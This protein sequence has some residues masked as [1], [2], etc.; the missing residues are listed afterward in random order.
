MHDHVRAAVLAAFAADALSL[1]VHWIYNTRV[2][3]RKYGR[4]ET[5]LKPELA[6]FHA[7][8]EKGDLT[9][10]GDQMLLL[11]ETVVAAGGF[12]PQAFAARWQAFAANYGG[13]MDKASKETLENFS[14]GKR[15]P[16][17]GSASTD[18]AGAARI[19]PLLIHYHQRPEELVAAARDQTAV[20]HNHPEVIACAELY[21]RAVFRVLAG[22]R[23]VAAL[24]DA[25]EETA[26]ADR[27]RDFIAAGLDSQGLDTRAAILDLGQACEVAQALP[28]TIHLIASYEDDLKTALVENIMAGGDSAARGMLVGLLL[29]ADQG[30]QAVPGDWLSGINAYR[31]ISG[32]LGLT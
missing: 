16:A 25:L 30:R 11:L 17:T 2:I 3:D 4:V 18:L 29:G 9:H 10:Y 20:T 32:L 6:K 22:S 12:D 14:A 26:G 28:S 27:I 31:R 7:G 13:Y 19:A 15:Y 8:K 5:L 24:K 1:G 23:P 21:A